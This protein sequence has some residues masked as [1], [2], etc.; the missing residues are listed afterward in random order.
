MAV[1]QSSGL[2]TKPARIHGWLKAISLVT[3]LAVFALVVLGG[4]VRVTGSGLG[5]PDWPLC[6]GKFLPPLEFT[7]VVEYS[8]RFVAS[9]I[10][11]PLIVVT[12]LSVLVL[13]WRERWLSIPAALGLILLAVQ[14]QLGRMTVL[15]ELPGEIVAIHLAVAEALLGCLILL[16]VVAFRGP[17]VVGRGDNKGHP[18]DEAADRFSKFAIVSALGVYIL[19]MSGSLVTASGATAACLSWPLCQ[20]QLFPEGVPAAIHMGHRLVAVVVGLLVLFSVHLGFRGKVHNQAVRL[21]S[22]SVAALFVMQIVLGAITV[23]AGFPIQLTA[24]HLAMGTAVWAAISATAFVSLTPRRP[25]DFYGES[26][27]ET[28]AQGAIA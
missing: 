12:C 24:L 27:S 6:Y 19:I 11:G 26:S 16:T 1:G 10:V 3:V 28:S 20:G 4:V 17:L 9:A 7:A 18:M 22:G 8:H 15:R 21:L 5:C 13:H 14:V 2:P 25:I 23:F